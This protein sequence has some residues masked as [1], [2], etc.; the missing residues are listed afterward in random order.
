[1]PQP[2]R[3]SDLAWST[4][5][6]ARMARVCEKIAEGEGADNEAQEQYRILESFLER[7]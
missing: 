7:G 5:M 4:A 2:G 3:R 6:N 1:M